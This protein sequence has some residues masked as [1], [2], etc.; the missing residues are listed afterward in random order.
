MKRNGDFI[1]AVIGASVMIYVA[2][3]A[4]VWAIT[5]SYIPK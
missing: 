5:G 2:M 3:E 1:L 4:I